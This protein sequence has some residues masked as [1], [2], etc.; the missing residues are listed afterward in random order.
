MNGFL[1]LTGGGE[2]IQVTDN[3]F[4]TIMFEIQDCPAGLHPR[5]QGIKMLRSFFLN[6][7]TGI[8]TLSLV[9]AKQMIEN[10]MEKNGM[11]W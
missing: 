9:S 1:T 6:K 3:Q 7:T 5:I 2:T 10:I 4:N 8:S 11:K